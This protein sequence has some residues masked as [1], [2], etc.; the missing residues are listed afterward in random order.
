MRHRIFLLCH[1]NVPIQ[2]FSCSL[3]SNYIFLENLTFNSCQLH[4]YHT[5][6]VLY[7]HILHFS[8]GYTA[9]ELCL[10]GTPH[11]PEQKINSLSS[12]TGMLQE[13]CQIIECRNLLKFTKSMFSLNCSANTHNLIISV[14]IYITLT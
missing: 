3:H 7:L 5:C 13:I 1:N 4:S 10:A 14:L 8:N 11:S 6:F 12:Y 9:L 2:I